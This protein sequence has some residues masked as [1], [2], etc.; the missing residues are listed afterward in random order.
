[1]NVHLL[2]YRLLLT[3]KDFEEVRTVMDYDF[4]TCPVC[5][6]KVLAREPYEKTWSLAVRMGLNGKEL[7]PFG[8]ELFFPFGRVQLQGMC[9]YCDYEKLRK[10]ELENSHEQRFR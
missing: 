4:A 2:F 3:L 5:R 8:V 9:N 7:K 10:F 1:L 6:R